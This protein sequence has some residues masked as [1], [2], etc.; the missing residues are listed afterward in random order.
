MPSQKV[1]QDDL[2]Q[3][4]VTVIYKSDDTRVIRLKHADASSVIYKEQLRDNAVAR[5]RHERRILELLSKVPGVPRLVRDNSQVPA[6][7]LA[8]EDQDCQCSNEV[9]SPRS[10]TQALTRF[11]IQ[12]TRILR[13]VH[14]V[15]VIHKD[16]TSSNILL[17]RESCQPI[18]ID[19]NLAT[20]F[21]VVARHF[22]KKILCS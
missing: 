19:F 2:A 22:V 4:E 7:V 8:L 13:E 15:G 3:H 1:W 11:A 21:A 5:V 17:L 12:V 20:T 10:S 6:N 16:I 18:L 9:F 14:Q